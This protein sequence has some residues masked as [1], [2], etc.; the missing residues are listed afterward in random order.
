MEAAKSADFALNFSRLFGATQLFLGFC[1][2][3]DLSTPDLSLGDGWCG[4]SST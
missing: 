1:L 3:F 4:E 2:R